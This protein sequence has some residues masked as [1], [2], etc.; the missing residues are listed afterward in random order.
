MTL[1]LVVLDKSSKYWKDAMRLCETVKSQTWSW[2][3]NQVDVQVC[4]VHHMQQ[5]EIAKLF[6]KMREHLEAGGKLAVSCWQS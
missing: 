1:L 3:R 5:E 6:A 4:P 2:G